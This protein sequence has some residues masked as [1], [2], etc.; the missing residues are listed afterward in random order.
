MS[1]IERAT[2]E[3][4][5]QDRLHWLEGRKYPEFSKLSHK[6]IEE[7]SQSLWVH[8]LAKDVCDIPVLE[9]SS[10]YN[11]FRIIRT[12]RGHRQ[13]YS[14]GCEVI[15]YYALKKCNLNVTIKESTWRT[16]STWST[17]WT[18]LL[19][20]VTLPIL[21]ASF[22]AFMVH[23]VVALV[24]LFGTIDAIPFITAGACEHVLVWLGFGQQVAFW[25]SVGCT[26][27]ITINV[28]IGVCNRLCTSRN[29]ANRAKTASEILRSI[30]MY[31]KP[32]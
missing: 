24:H 9:N 8:L 14:N 7:I 15:L 6:L 5:R 10:W 23:T 26:A 28:E 31:A 16:W 25:T 20:S 27:R 19:A 11:V 18:C 2:F 32:L 3:F 30:A 4:I 12:R 1:S 13:Y 21:A 29:T 22:A 17:C